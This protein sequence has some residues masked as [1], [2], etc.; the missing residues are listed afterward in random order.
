MNHAKPNPVFRELSQKVAV[1]HTAV[2]VVDMQ[3]DFCAEGGAVEK[4]GRDM[5]AIF[6]MVSQLARFINKTRKYEVPIIFIRTIRREEEVSGPMQEIWFRH[7]VDTPICAAGTWGAEMIPEIRIQAE[8]I[9]IEKKRYSAFFQTDLENT[10]GSKGIRTL[11]VTGTATNV[12]VETTCRDG[13]MRDFYVV[14]PED[15]VACT[16]PKV[17]QNSLQNIDRY[18]GTLTTSGDIIRIWQGG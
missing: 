5:G 15:L 4:A 17:H 11:I 18:F 7:H 13:F 12:C 9:I 10:L 14:V 6:E 3:N 1:D 8:D 2:V 16:D